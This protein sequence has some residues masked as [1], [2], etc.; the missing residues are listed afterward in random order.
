MI[1]FLVIAELDELV[2]SAESEMKFIEKHNAN[3]SSSRNVAHY[4][5][6]YQVESIKNINPTGIY[7]FTVI[8]PHE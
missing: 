1:F 6:E 3:S 4:S 2:H 7:F 8:G 5:G